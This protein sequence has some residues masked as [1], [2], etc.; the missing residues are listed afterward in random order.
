MDLFQQSAVGS[1]RPT[2]VVCPATRPGEPAPGPAGPVCLCHR[3][4]L[5]S[6]FSRPAAGGT[7]CDAR[8]AA[9]ASKHRTALVPGEPQLPMASRGPA[10]PTRSSAR[11]PSSQIPQVGHAAGGRRARGQQTAATAAR[12]GNRSH[13]PGRR[14]PNRQ[15]ASRGEC[16]DYNTWEVT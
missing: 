7:G 3:G 4:S 6:G 11:R 5:S 13:L 16:S 2:Y 15:V 8:G 9:A 12:D 14:T 10:D 1:V